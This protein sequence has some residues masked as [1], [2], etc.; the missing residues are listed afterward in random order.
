MEMLLR[1]ELSKDAGPRCGRRLLCDAA[2]AA[3][4]ARSLSGRGKHPSIRCV[5]FTIAIDI[6]LTHNMSLA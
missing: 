5:S 6:V 2:A 3:R 4:F 1:V